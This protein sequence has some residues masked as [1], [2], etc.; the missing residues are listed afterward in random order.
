MKVPVR[1]QDAPSSALAN[2]VVAPSPYFG[3]EQVWDTS[4]QRAQ[5]DAGSGRARLLHGTNPFTQE[6]ASVLRG[7]VRPSV[8]EGVPACGNPLWVRAEL[9]SGHRLRPEDQA[10][11][12]HRHVFRDTPFEFCRGC[13]SHAVAQQ[14][15]PK[16]ACRRRLG[17]HEAVLGD[18]RCGE[19]AG[20]D[21]VN[22]RHQRQ[23]QAGRLCG[24]QPAGRPHQG[25]AYRTRLLR[26]C[27]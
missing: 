9:T 13:Q 14:Q 12:V 21:A 2:P 18:R 17:Q 10:V 15:H 19:V 26:H 11:H 4:G 22:C 25:Q 5:P 8:G 23:R 20:L 27:L 16:R 7:R 1:D 24:T 6:S 3:A